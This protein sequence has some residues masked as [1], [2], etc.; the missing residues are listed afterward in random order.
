MILSAHLS[1]R[2]NAAFAKLTG[3]EVHKSSPS[4]SKVRSEAMDRLSIDTIIDGGANC[5]QWAEDLRARNGGHGV[6]HSFEP[7]PSAYQKLVAKSSL[8][9]NWV[10]HNLALGSAPGLLEISISSN[11]AMSSSALRLGLHAEIYPNVSYVGSVTA[12]MARL[13]SLASQFGGSIFLKL[14]LQGYEPEALE[15]ASGIMERVSLIEIETC[16]SPMYVGQQTHYEIVPSL[17]D[18]GFVYLTA[19]PPSKTSMG[20]SVYTD[21]LLMRREFAEI[22]G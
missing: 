14:D 11:S 10:P 1:E 22:F 9:D 2:M 16:Y 13:D 7:V 3:F 19:T 5:G 20:K 17:L 21:V 8:V 6:M 18:M 15:G 12:Q 4:F